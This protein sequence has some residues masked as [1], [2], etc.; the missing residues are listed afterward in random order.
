MKQRVILYLDDE[1]KNL[2]HTSCCFLPESAGQWS[3]FELAEAHLV[4][5]GPSSLSS[6]QMTLIAASFAAKEALVWPLPR[7]L[8]VAKSTTTA[9]NL[10]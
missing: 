2:P 4:F 3:C 6:G 9:A 8:L 10:C 1:I 7:L 5:F